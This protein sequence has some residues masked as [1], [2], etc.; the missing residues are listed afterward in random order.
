M[1]ELLK[2]QKHWRPLKE[3]RYEKRQGK[4]EE[5]KPE[6]KQQ[7]QADMKYG[8]MRARRNGVSTEML[9]RAVWAASGPGRH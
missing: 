7:Y 5:G 2:L 3:L 9:I 4:W 1:S 6:R 8:A